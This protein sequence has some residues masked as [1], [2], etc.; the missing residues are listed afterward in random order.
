M[1][2][3]P[4]SRP[5]LARSR[6]GARGGEGDGVAAGVLENLGANLEDVRIESEKI[7]SENISSPA[8]ATAK[9]KSK[10]P[11]IAELGTDQTPLAKNNRLDPDIGRE[12]ELKRMIQILCRRT[13]N[14]PVLIGESGVGKTAIV[15]KLAQNIFDSNVPEMIKSKRVITLDIGSLVA[16]T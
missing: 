7:L 1:P 4:R 6:G 11:M 12:E 9:V 10:T 8:P 14:N 16:G 3:A 5:R 2:L 13:K 15:E